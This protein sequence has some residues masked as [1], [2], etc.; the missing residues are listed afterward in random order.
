MIMVLKR[1]L[2]S[3]WSVLVLVLLWQLSAT[4]GSYN[5]IVMPSPADV[6][7]ALLDNPEFF[8]LETSY[9]LGFSLAGLFFG[10]GIGS[11]SLIHISEP[12]RPY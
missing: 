12:T 10:M 2:S 7:F 5:I 8:V 11:L 9:T 1:M 4:V 3:Y 6:F